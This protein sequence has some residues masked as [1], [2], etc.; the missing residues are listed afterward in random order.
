MMPS[1]PR[2]GDWVEVAIKSGMDDWTSRRMSTICRPRANAK[3]SL[4]KA[5]ISGDARRKLERAA[6]MDA[7]ISGRPTDVAERG[8]RLQ[9]RRIVVASQAC[10]EPA[11][12]EMPQEVHRDLGGFLFLRGRRQQ[13]K[14]KVPLG[15]APVPPVFR[16]ISEHQSSRESQ[17][18]ALARHS[19]GR[20][21]TGRPSEPERR[22]SEW[23]VA[24]NAARRARGMPSRGGRPL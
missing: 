12:S 11:G 23:R 3:S 24:A 1:S 9:E 6:E 2:A 19:Q 14:Q 8:Q 18:T 10:T 21:W 4:Q 5:N 16:S 15:R 20:P 22:S 17:H 7:L 13:R